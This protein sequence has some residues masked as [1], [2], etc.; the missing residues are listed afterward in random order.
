M[1]ILIRWFPRLNL[2]TVILGTFVTARVGGVLRGDLLANHA[3]PTV[4]SK[5]TAP[6]ARSPKASSPSATHASR[7]GPRGP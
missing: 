4:A 3:P 6:K 1:I 7:H 2:S 5:L